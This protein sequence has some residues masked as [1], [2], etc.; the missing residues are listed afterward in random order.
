MEEKP[1]KDHANGRENAT[2]LEE[3]LTTHGVVFHHTTGH[4]FTVIGDDHIFIVNEETPNHIESFEFKKVP[5]NKVEEFTVSAGS[6]DDRYTSD[7]AQKATDGSGQ[8]K[9]TS[10]IRLRVP[11]HA[12][13]CYVDAD[14]RKVASAFVTFSLGAH[15]NSTP[16][17]ESEQSL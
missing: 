9:P 6:R 2:Q 17:T 16:N 14:P 13:D 3:R 10:H 4:G 12:I 15:P 5:F 11:S 7:N 1:M 8:S